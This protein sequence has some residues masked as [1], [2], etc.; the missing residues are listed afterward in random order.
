MSESTLNIIPQQPSFVPDVINMLQAGEFLLTIFPDADN[1]HSET[2]D[3]IRFIDAGEN[4][5]NITCPSCGEE[6][7]MDWWSEAMGKAS[8]SQ[9]GN[10]D[11]RVPCCTEQTTLNNLTY[12]F[13]QGFARCILSVTNPDVSEIDEQ[14]KSELEKILG[15]KLR[16]IFVHY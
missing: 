13:P 5:E 15:C 8:E 4:F 11:V 3:E 2:F 16:I 9:F 12:H 1:I 6:I 10:L 7:L 14:T